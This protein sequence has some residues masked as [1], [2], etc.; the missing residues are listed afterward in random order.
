[1]KIVFDNEDFDSQFLRAL[2]YTA[3]GGADIGECFETAKNIKEGNR[4][5]WYDAWT[6]TA[7]RMRQDAEESLK[8]GHNVSARRSYL[9]A[10]N[11]YRA[12]E[13][14]VRDD[15]KDPRSLQ[16]WQASHDCF[17]RAAELFHPPFE[18]VEIPYDGTT[19]PGYFF[20][21]DDSGKRRPT[22]IT[23]TGMDGY[24]EETYFGTVAAALERD[25]NCLTYDGPGQGGVLRQREVP[26][27]PDWEAVVTPVV[28]FAV[29][30]PEVDQERMV[31][32][33]RSFGG[34]LA[35]RAAALE[36]R[37]AALIADPGQFDEFDLAMTRMPQEIREAIEQDD[38]KVD[39]FLEKMVQDD[40]GRF[41]LAARMR[42]FGAKTLKELVLMQREYSLKGLAE[43]IK[44]PTLVCDNVSDAVAGGQGKEL[45]EALRCPKNY[46]LFTAEEGAEGHCEGGAQVL[47][48][49]KVFDWL[50]KTLM[51]ASPRDAVT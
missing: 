31:L 40:A 10:S 46:V 42:A 7:E 48:H 37:L 15:P 16:G 2:S 34:Y 36:H 28:D 13:F 26:L 30:I 11:Y 47:F 25:Y 50:D 21:V 29:G 12:A 4:D 35:P 8:G 9:R 1:M 43:K 19:L 33:G 23:M 17:A 41:F 32:I 51:E 27:R 38:P 44:C 24:Q 14:Y 49:S 39:S 5:S 22:V 45:Y 3:Y 20:R 6:K 18:A